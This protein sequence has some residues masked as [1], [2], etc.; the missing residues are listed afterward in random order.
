MF[1]I[2]Q[3]DVSVQFDRQYDYRILRIDIDRIRAHSQQLLQQRFHRKQLCRFFGVLGT[4][5]GFQRK[6]QPYLIEYGY[7]FVRNSRR[8]VGAFFAAGRIVFVGIYGGRQSRFERD[9]GRIAEIISDPERVLVIGFVGQTDKQ[10]LHTV[11]LGIAY[12]QVPEHRQFDDGVAHHIAE[13]GGNTEVVDQRIQQRAGDRQRSFFLSQSYQKQLVVPSELFQFH[14][15]FRLGT[16]VL[17]CRLQAFESRRQ[18][19]R[20]FC[21]LFVSGYVDYAVQVD[22]GNEFP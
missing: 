6:G 4:D 21:G 8:D 17:G 7:V 3:I 19:F 16:G 13:Q 12:L 2:R 18:L 14:P 11:F 9:G 5:P 1:D 10:T 22:A 15:V 20:A